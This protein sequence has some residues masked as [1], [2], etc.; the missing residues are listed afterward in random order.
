M[1][2]KDIIL[3]NDLNQLMEYIRNNNIKTEQ[4]DTNYKRVI[5][6]FC[7][8]S[9][10]SDDLEKFINTFFDTRKYEVIKIIERRDLN[11]LKQYKDKHIDEFKELD[12]NDFNIMEY[13]YD[14]DH[15]VP[16]SIKKYITQ[17]YTKERREVL[18]LIQKN[19]IKTLIEH[20]KENHF[21][22]VDD[23]II[24]FDDLDDD[25]FNIVEFCKTTKH[26]CDNMKNYVINHYTKNRSCIVES[27]RR[28]NIREM[29]RYIN[30]YGIEI[31]SIN[32]QYFNIFDYCDE[33][34]SNKSL[35]SKMK[36]IMLKNYDEL[37]LK[38][39]EMLSNGF[40]K[41][42]FNYINDKNMEF[43]DLD[44]ENFNIIKFC[45]SEYS[46]IDSDSRNYVISHYNRQRG[47]IVDFITNGEL[48]KLKDFLRENKLNL[49]DINDNMF[50]IKKYTLSLYNDNDSVIDCEMKDYIVIHTDKKKK[51][52]IEIIEKN[53]V[54]ILEEYINEN[55]LQFKDIDNKYLNFIN[56]VKRIYENQ[57][58]SKE[59]LQLVFLHYDTTIREII[60]TIQRNDFEEFKNYILEHKTEYK[61]FNIKYFNII[62]MLLFN[63]IIGS[64]RLNILISDF[65]NKK[66]C[67]IL[68]YIFKS[69]ISHLKEYIQDN[70]INELI[71]LNDSYFDINEFYLSFQ[72]S[73]SEEINY[74][75]IIHLNQQRSQIIE[76]IDNEQSFELTRYTEENHFEFKSLNYLNFNI[77]EY[78][79]TMKFSSNI[80]R[81]III[82]YD[83][84][85]SNLV[86]TINK[87]TLKELKDYVKEN[88][89]EFRK[90]NDKYFN[91]FDYCDSCDAKDYIINHYY[92]ERN[93]I[94]NFI[95]DNNLTGLKLYLIENNIELEDINDNLFNIKQ[96]IYA[97]YDE[98]LIIEDIKD[99]IN[100]YT[101][102]KKR[103]IIEI[104]E[105]NRITDLKSYVEKNKF[106][107]KTL[108]DGRLDIINYIMNIY[109]NGI[110]SS[111]IKHFIFSHFDNVIYKIIEIIKRN[112][113][114]EL[115]NYI[116]NN[117]LNYKII[118][119]NYF[120][121]I[122]AI[123][124]DNPHISVDLKDFIKVFI[125][126][127][128]YVIIDIIMNNSLTRLKQYKKE[129]HIGGFNELNDQHFNIMEFCKSNNKISSD[130]ILY[131]NSHMYENRSK[132]IEMIDNKNLSELEKYTEV[133]HYEYKSL[134][135][136][137]FNIENYCEKKNITS[138]IKNHILIHYDK[139]RFKIVTLI[140]DII[141]AEKRKRTFNN[142][143]IFRS[144]DEQQNQY[145][146]PEP[147][148]LL[149]VF[150][151]YVENFCIQFQNINDDYF[152]IIEFLDLKDQETIVNIINTH[153]SE[154]R[155][156]IFDY[157]KNSN[158]YELKNYTI[159]N[160]IILEKLNT[161]EFDILSYSMKHLNPSTKIVDYIINQRG[162]DFSIYK[163]LKL[164]E[165]PLYIALS[166][167]NY[168]MANM[169]LKNKMD[170][171]SHGCSLI[172][173]R[174]INMQ[175]NI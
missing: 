12:N 87:K 66:K 119:K 83:N 132:I 77:I 64:P 78:C 85:R 8:Y 161:K 116:S 86:N 71:E 148:H 150:K 55:N 50:N 151:E 99:F 34:I 154:Q 109:D 44:D 142:N 103:E 133:N 80:I 156:K 40:K 102:K 97:L 173:D 124:S 174:I 107:F 73:F 51:E 28:K 92:K 110:I 130:I 15:Q 41:S 36:Y 111:E 29:K 157:I 31:K 129:Y 75:I 89:I 135:D 134:N 105:R 82:N 126:P 115:M 47:T 65:F 160:S 26:I 9:S 94:V 48:M 17:H 37:H 152:D 143:T 68:E 146:G 27:I 33:E 100:I 46:R 18:K 3:R 13:I 91:I 43:K 54:N 16:I 159:E 140:K 141:D 30:N 67:Y 32:D 7:R 20:I 158:L 118:N 6:Y 42:S 122:E 98:G 139:F 166:K 69:D 84:N 175:L 163:K 23:E 95:E 138:N 21:I 172:K 2:I 53:N 147:E 155:S 52:V 88:N 164:T 79:K 96:Y 81:Y 62:E 1:E 171:N 114:D 167:D 70:H 49:E 123:R 104:I 59:V 137:E 74:F 4:I 5:D 60:E 145:S 131:I 93:D 35:S 14:M 168:E 25:Y 57:I 128:K 144:L 45:D 153:Y 162:Y 56:Y 120:D 10:L 169:L 117:K 61:L 165:F 76:M 19:N 38:V 127:K 170:I 106:E 39:I 125:E 63:L 90:M 101:D 58:I 108:N 24:Y 112:S 121:I 136:E 22:F 113:L 149:N 11:E 72:N